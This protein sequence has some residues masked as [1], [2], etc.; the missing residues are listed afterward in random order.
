M[1]EA[2]HK[3]LVTSNTSPKEAA[4]K[5]EEN[6]VI[7]DYAHVLEAIT[8]CLEGPVRD[9]LDKWVVNLMSEDETEEVSLI[10]TDINN[11]RKQMLCEEF[12]AGNVPLA[13][14]IGVQNIIPKDV[15][16]YLL[17]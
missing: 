12:K 15:K 8:C 3:I 1:D 17:R 11:I 2:C 10:K 16:K 5:E 9:L 7:V 4:E 6:I 13:S 14:N